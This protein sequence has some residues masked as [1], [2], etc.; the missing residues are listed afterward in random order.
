MFSPAR[1]W[2]LL[3]EKEKVVYF[4]HDYININSRGIYNYS[5]FRYFYNASSKTCDE[6]LYGGC[7]GNENRFSDIEGCE[8]ICKDRELVEPIR[9]RIKTED[10]TTFEDGFDSW[11][12][13]SWGELRY[14]S[15]DAR[16]MGV[17]PPP[18]NQSNP[19]IENQVNY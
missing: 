10:F 18:Q 16:G 11:V 6:F 3:F 15:D 14:H 13:H 2:P 5:L 7:N 19:N 12:A 9:S 1:D 4:S 17:G 8:E